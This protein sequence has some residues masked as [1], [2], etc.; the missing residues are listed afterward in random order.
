MPTATLMHKSEVGLT[1]RG[2]VTATPQASLPPSR[3][4]PLILGPFQSLVWIRTLS[5]PTSVDHQ[6]S[7]TPLRDKPLIP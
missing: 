1:V 2:Q 3:D 4:L 7:P 5:P 6:P